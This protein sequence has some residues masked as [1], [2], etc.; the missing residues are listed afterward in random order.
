MPPQPL[1]EVI[2]EGRLWRPPHLPAELARRILAAPP[3][4]TVHSNRR[5]LVERVEVEGARYARKRYRSTPIRALLGLAGGR[6]RARRSFLLAAEGERRGL[7]LLRPVC[8][9]AHRRRG[10]PGESILVTR[11]FEGEHL[12]LFHASRRCTSLAPWR[13][14]VE[15]LGRLA[16]F[17]LDLHRGGVLALDL[18]PQNVLAREAEGGGWELSLADLDDARLA[19]AVAP[20]QIADNLAQLGHLPATV[21]ARERRRFFGIYLEEGGRELLGPLLER[22]GERALLREIEE[23]ID[24]LHRAKLRR[25]RA[26]HGDPHRYAGWGL[27]AEG[28]PEG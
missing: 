26:R 17:L 18:A 16:R 22:D 6:A 1:E 15:F 9:L 25:M 23:R 12:H 4:A 13:A 11:W 2:A 8:L 14:R 28:R 10:I 27:D 20:E 19:G 7:P 5:S 3:S 24:R 21:P